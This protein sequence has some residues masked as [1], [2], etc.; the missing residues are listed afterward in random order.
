MEHNLYKQIYQLVIKIANRTYLK[1]AQY[2]DARILLV[3]I[4]AVL[5]DRP[6]YWACK[7]SNWPIYLRRDSLPSASTMSRRL[8]TRRIQILIKELERAARSS[9]PA[10]LCKWMDAKPLPIGRHT[11]DKYAGFGP[12]AGLIAAG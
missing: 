7:K 9:L 2:T 10:G 12:A 8:R 4:W 11:K 5:H 1:K 6:I 3:Y